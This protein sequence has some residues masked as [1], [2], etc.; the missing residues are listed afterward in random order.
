M[1]LD[2]DREG[3]WMS[4]R[5][6]FVLACALLTHTAMAA[7]PFEGTWKL[8]PEKSK[9]GVEVVEITMTIT[10]TGPNS[11]RTTQDITF[12]SGEKRHQEIDRIFDGKEHSVT[13]TGDHQRS[14]IARRV[15]ATTREIIDK[16][17]GKITEKVVS[18]VAPDGHTM[19]NVERESNGN[20]WISIYARP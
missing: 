17:D 12:K 19:K 18:V 9:L 13:A 4:S 2:T 14:I 6:R 1:R 5:L 11:F 3:V 16:V 7:E 15:D 20:E 8:V 10:Q